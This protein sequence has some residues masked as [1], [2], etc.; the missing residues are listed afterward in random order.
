MHDRKQRRLCGVHVDTTTRRAP[1]DR[2]PVCPYVPMREPPLLEGEEPAGDLHEAAA[3]LRLGQACI[4][5]VTRVSTGFRARV[6]GR[7]LA[8][9]VPTFLPSLAPA[10]AHTMHAPASAVEATRPKR[11]PRGE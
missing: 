10:S 7:A 9:C 11:S 6:V 8:R 5:A 3:R 2:L 1:D 4:V